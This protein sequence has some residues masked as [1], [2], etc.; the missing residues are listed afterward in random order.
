M[1]K[2]NIASV[3][4]NALGG[5]TLSFDAVDAPVSSLNIS[6]EKIDNGRFDEKLIKEGNVAIVKP[7]KIEGSQQK[8]QLVGGLFN[9]KGKATETA[10]M[11]VLN[12]A[13]DAALVA[14]APE[15]R[16]G[17]FVDSIIKASNTAESKKKE[18]KQPATN[19][20]AATE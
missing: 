10:D 7:Y 13:I 8:K 9:L 17:F 14:D 5:F 12:N 18:S 15:A 20:K 16:E 19:T 4:T 1:I 11:Y 2:L 6:K 3:T